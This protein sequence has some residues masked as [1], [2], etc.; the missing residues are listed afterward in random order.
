MTPFLLKA[1]HPDSQQILKQDA[2]PPA[3]WREANASGGV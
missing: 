1:A 2:Y 3:T